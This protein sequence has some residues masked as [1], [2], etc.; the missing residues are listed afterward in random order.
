MGLVAGRGSG[1]K[2]AQYGMTGS[3]MFVTKVCWLCVH[4]C[5]QYSMLVREPTQTPRTITST[6]HATAHS[7]RPLTQ[8]QYLPTAVPGTESTEVALQ[9]LSLYRGQDT[10]E[11]TATTLNLLWAG[12]AMCVCITCIPAALAVLVGGGTLT[13]LVWKANA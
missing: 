7:S 4:V 8:Q 9:W 12:R 6:N 1:T 11:V 2:P 10:P 5:T 3:T 13:E